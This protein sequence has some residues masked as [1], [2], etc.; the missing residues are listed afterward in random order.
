MTT[1]IQPLGGP[2]PP[3]LE[4]PELR[5]R[6]V[7]IA[8]ALP[9]LY[10]HAAGFFRRNGLSV[11]LRPAP[12]WSAIKELL[13][14]GQIDAAHVL[15]PMPL[16]SC[17]GID[18]RPGALRL[19]LIQNLNGQALTLASRHR[20]I[21]S[22]SELRGLTFGVPYLY[23]MQY[24]LL[25]HYLAEQGIDPLHDVRIIEVVPPQMPTYLRQQLID[26]FLGPTPYP[27]LVVERDIGF[28]FLLSQQIWPGHPCCGLAT[29]ASFIERA[30]HTARA[31][32][33]SVAQAQRHIE[34]ADATERRE[35]VTAVSGPAYLNLRQQ[36][37]MTAALVGH[38]A[39]GRGGQIEAPDFLSF[40]A[41]PLPAHGQWIVSQMQRWGQLP[42]ELDRQALVAEVFASELFDALPSDG[43]SR[44]QPTIAA[45]PTPPLGD[46]TTQPF[47][48]PRTQ[49][50]APRSYQLSAAL[51]QRLLEMLDQLALVAGGQL[52]DAEELKVT[53]DD[54]F[55]WL[56]RMIG[57]IVRNAKFGQQQLR[58]QHRLEEES[59][60]QQALIATQQDLL[61]QLSTPIIPL[62]P[63]CLLVPLIGDIDL[64]RAQQISTTV[65][66][67]VTLHRASIVL[68]DITGLPAVDQAAAGYFRQVAQAVALIG[69]Q[70]VLVGVSS[71]VAMTLV[72]L[73]IDLSALT[74]QRD[75]ASAVSYALAQRRLQIVPMAAPPAAGKRSL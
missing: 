9:L 54:A 56:E 51:H 59:F 1:P 73:G 24:Y 2:S 70:T 62:L 4:Q 68:L 6:F 7:A 18:G 64:G 53:A 31:L 39:D 60:R 20:A 13:V 5:L 17:A 66:Q 14:H 63:G 44:H 23:S 15:S 25:C 3:P 65:L 57:E 72:G 37:L 10:A 71:K 74:I 21:R 22:P 35:I 38:F 43:P 58:E 27:Q 26:G 34:Q 19:L 67:A 55:G 32:L 42:I 48:A 12:G 29:T 47:A 69:A 52:D 75:L 33:R 28:L 16:A 36:T 40:A 41:Q 49:P 11:D 30:P 8:C 46:V 61:R 45:P 50:A